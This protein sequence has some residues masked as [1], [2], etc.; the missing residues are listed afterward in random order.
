MRILIVE[1]FFT[2][3]HASWAEGY[4]QH[5]THEVEILSMPG[6]HWKWRMHG[7]AVTLSSQFK[8]LE[9]KPDLILATDMLDFPVFLGLCGKDA[10]GIPTAVYFHENQLS[11]PWSPEDDDISKGRDFHYGFINWT[12][13]LAAQKVFFNSSYNLESFYAGVE[14]ML[15]AMP[16]ARSL[17]MLSG[18]KNKSTVLPL[19]IDLEPFHIS[20]AA[21]DYS[22]PIILWNHRWE[23]DKDPE[24]FFNAVSRLKDEKIEFEL[25]V[26]GEVCEKYPVVFD[27][28]RELFKNELFFMGYAESKEAYQKLLAR[29]NILPVT[30]NQEFFGQSVMEAVA[31]GCLPILP[32]ALAYP[33][34][35]PDSLRS[36]LLYKTKEVLHEKLR[37]ACLNLKGL[38]PFVT[39][40]QGVAKS[41]DWRQLTPVYDKAFEDLLG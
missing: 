2:G 32:Y 31:A 24:A 29:A 25:I 37:N 28:A 20:I 14:T 12:T 10:A 22:K 19:G 3:S 27:K 26:C 17:E 16:D 23:Y 8:K 21:K 18:A 38:K 11:Y 30:S 5:S 36:S 1:P 9:Q 15:K 40:M 41:Y 6:R 4:K 39:A 35:V 33:E 13:A 7:A 34:H